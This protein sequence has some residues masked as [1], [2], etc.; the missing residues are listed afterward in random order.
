MRNRST[1]LLLRLAIV[2][3]PVVILLSLLWALGVHAQP[4]ARPASAQTWTTGGPYGGEVRDLVVNPLNPDV[5]YALL[6]NAGLYMTDD[7]GASWRPSMIDP[8]PQ[9]VTLDAVDPD[10]MYFA[11][12]QHLYR[13]PDGGESWERIGALSHPSPHLFPITHPVSPGVLYLGVGVPVN[14][15]LLGDEITGVFRWDDATGEWSDMSTG[16][17][18]TLITSLAFLPDD[19]STMAASTR[20]GNVFL[21]EDGGNTWEWRAKVASY[22][23]RLAANPFTPGE[24]WALTKDPT[25]W[26]EPPTIFRSTDASL[27]D[28]EPLTFPGDIAPVLARSVTFVDGDPGVAYLASHGEPALVSTD[29]GDSWQVMAGSP[30]APTCF[31]AVGDGLRYIGTLQ[32]GAYVSADG[33]TRW[34]ASSVGLAGVLPESMVAVPGAPAIAFAQTESLGLLRTADGGQ[35]WEEIA[36]VRREGFPWRDSVLAAQGGPEGRVYLGSQ[37]E[38]L[39]CL[40]VGDL[41]GASWETYLVPMPPELE[42]DTRA[43][44]FAV[45]ADPTRPGRVLAGITFFPPGV[46]LGQPKRVLGAISSSD[47]YGATWETAYGITATLP[48]SGVIEFA[49][50]PAAPEVIWAA[51]DGTGLLRTTDGGDTWEPVA[52]WAGPAFVRSVAV[53][54]HSPQTVYVAATESVPG[55]LA[56]VYVSHDGGETWERMEGTGG[57]AWVLHMAASEP[58]VLYLG[59]WGG[60]VRRL[61]PDGQWSNLTAVPERSNVFSIA[62]GRDEDRAIV[63]VALSGDNGTPPEQLAVGGAVLLASEARSGGIYQLSVPDQQAVYLPLS[64]RQ[65][66][67]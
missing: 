26:A 20:N 28:W 1:T 30:P 13:S 36:G 49:S 19:P 52:G 21:T 33:G 2:A 34:E 9:G 38:G 41:D 40:K 57:D 67:P 25:V 22:I 56:G 58:P 43:D 50:S 4:A 3:L 29:G 27:T 6:H 51:T 55:E 14:R 59:T 8:W 7:G 16:I 60:G 12:Q 32:R 15:P 48:I 62:S 47:D 44:V 11:G 66:A 45:Y 17:T 31:G 53:D 54:R 65:F 39:P 10:L 37:C 24:V 5:A 35:T 64:V 18:D 46:D 42:A 61:E 23:Y 63:Y